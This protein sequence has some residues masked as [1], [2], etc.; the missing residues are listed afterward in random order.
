MS[1]FQGVGQLFQPLTSNATLGRVWRL[2]ESSQRW[3]FYDPRP[4]FVPF[5]TLRTVNLASDPPAVVAINVTRNQRFRGI[6]LYAGWNYVPVTSEPLAA[7]PGS[8]S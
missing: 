2:I 8:G 1:N 5:N 3:L 7:Q 6:P 4:S